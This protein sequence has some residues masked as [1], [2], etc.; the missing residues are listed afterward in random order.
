M[1]F[2]YVEI[3]ANDRGNLT[4]KMP[5]PGLVVEPIPMYFKNIPKSHAYIRKRIAVS[6]FNGRETMRFYDREKLSKEDGNMFLA[7]CAT[8][9][10]V[11]RARWA[12]LEEWVEVMVWDVRK[13]VNVFDISRI[14]Y[15]KIDA[16]GMD[17]R[18]VT[19]LFEW[20]GC[21]FIDN[22]QFETNPITPGKELEAARESLAR[23]GYSRVSDWNDSHDSVYRL[24][25]Q[26]P[27]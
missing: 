27:L 11:E 3:G 19:R 6:D 16:E 22:V 18:I 23:K 25:V 21:P 1:D 8:L 10:D 2:N 14:H 4:S 13:L 24:S 12:H 17:S 15:L 7:G 26:P 9:G 20:N 5:G